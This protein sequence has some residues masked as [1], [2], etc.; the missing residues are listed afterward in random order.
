MAENSSWEDKPGEGYAHP[1]KNKTQDWH[2]DYAG[3]IIIPADAVPGE[4]YWMSV[5]DGVSQNSGNPYRRIKLGNKVQ[6]S[7]E[8]SAPTPA[9]KAETVDDFKDDIP[10]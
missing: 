3:Q 4:R 2:D 8:T 6:A 10:F 7:N 1:A 5:K 9:P